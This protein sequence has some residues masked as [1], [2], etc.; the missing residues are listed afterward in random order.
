[1]RRVST[2]STSGSRTSPATTS[3]SRTSLGDATKECQWEFIRDSE[4]R[5][6]YEAARDKAGRLVYGLLYVPTGRPT[7]A[8]AFY[9]DHNGL[10]QARSGSGA[11]YV[12]IV[13]SEQGFDREIR[14]FD[15][16]GNPQLNE[17]R[18]V[19]GAPGDRSEDRPPRQLH[20]PGPRREGRCSER[21]A[22]T[23]GQRDRGG[24]PRAAGSPA[25]DGHAGNVKPRRPTVEPTSRGRPTR[26]KEA[27]PRRLS[28]TT[29]G[30]TS[31][32][33][34][35][36]TSTAGPPGTR[37]ASPGSTAQYDERGNRTEAAYFDEHGR[38][39]RHKDRLRQVRLPSTTSGA[40]GP[41]GPTS[42]SR[43]GP[44]G[45]RTATPRST[46]KYDERGNRTEE[47]YFDEQGRPTRNKDGYAKATVKYDE[48]GN[49]GPRW[50]TSTSKAGPPGTRTASP[51]RP[52]YDERGNR[53]RRPTSTSRPAHPEQGRLRQVRPS[54][55]DERGNRTE[56]AYFDEQGRPTRHKDGYARLTATLRRA[57]QP[58]RG[59]PTSTSKAGPP[60]TRTATPGGRQVRRAGQ[61]DRGGLL[62]RAR[63]AHPAQGRLRQ[64][65]RPSYDERGNQTEEA[66]FDEA[67]PAHAAQ[68]RL[69]QVDCQV[70]R[71]GQP[72]EE[73]YFD[74]QGRPTR[75]KD[76]YA[77]LTA[78]YDERGN[79]TEEAYFDEARPAHPAQG[80]L[81]QGGPCQ[82]TTSGATGPRRP[83]STSKAGPPGTR[84]A[85]PG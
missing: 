16:K 72:D 62:R 29:S 24:L 41:R 27:T 26:H 48:R 5:V 7:E 30:A 19:R 85:T 76:G 20:R 3:G 33:R 55:Y 74:E 65:R 38:P 10:P 66:Y 51:G 2:S 13:R 53:P 6:V 84:T 67:R 60:G 11:A 18:G 56:V 54:S 9:I 83:T 49:I 23:S 21:R 34:P 61:P 78:K 31:P 81:R 59:W 80:R 69:R 70:R 8:T 71:A 37:M 25:Q 35:T 79:R 64:V 58:D 46:V 75:H 17:N 68:G 82:A 52:K 63:P 28:S 36:S 73:A 40:T 43:A 57:G 77:R 4:D 15:I 14:Y 42:T 39:T 22:T 44:P 50:P 45:T 1:M 47:A 32:R 12:K